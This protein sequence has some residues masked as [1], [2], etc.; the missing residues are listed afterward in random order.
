MANFRTWQRGLP[1]SIQAV[2]KKTDLDALAIVDDLGAVAVIAIFYTETIVWG[3]LGAGVLLLG[4]LIL[5]NLFGIRNPIPY[6][7]VGTLLWLALLQSV[8]HATVAGIL[9]AWT[10]P[11]RSKFDMVRFGGLIESMGERIQRR[12]DADQEC[13]IMQNDEQRRG[14]VQTLI[15]GIHMIETP[16][17]R[18][19]HSLHIPVAYLIIALFA[20]ANAGVPIDI[21]RIPVLVSES[22]TLGIMA[23]LV[24]GK[25]VG[26]TGATLFAAKLGLAE[27]PEGAK[28]GHIIGVGFLGGSGFTMSIFI[29]ELGFEDQEEALILAKTGVLFSSVIAGV[30]GMAWL[31]LYSKKAAA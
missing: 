28:L 9:T 3:A 24:L 7:L 25:L 10:I 14:D 6:F 22:I 2:P 30:I 13:E 31:Y 29:A 23:G 17:Q 21:D 12:I 26:I 18:L 11:A 5:F 1:Y 15:D 20:L 27:L 19:E 16:L 8:I 4:V